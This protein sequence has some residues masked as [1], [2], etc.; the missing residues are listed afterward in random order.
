MANEQPKDPTGKKGIGFALMPLIPWLAVT[1][2]AL[3][4]SGAFKKVSASQ[5]A[6]AASESSNIRQELK[7]CYE[8]LKLAARGIDEAPI[9]EVNDRLYDCKEELRQKLKGES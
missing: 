2:F 7:Q 5:N 8:K 1:L 4:Q 3:N 6:N 9:K